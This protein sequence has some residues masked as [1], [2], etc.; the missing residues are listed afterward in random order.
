[1][2][3]AALETV[4]N[5]A[6]QA[7]LANEDV[8][9]LR[10]AVDTLALM[11]AAL[12]AKSASIARLRWLMF[13]ERTEKTSRLFPAKEAE[14]GDAPAGADAEQGAQAEPE[15]TAES[16][17]DQAKTKK[18][19]HGRNGAAA[20][21]GATKIPVP[22]ESLTKGQ[23]CPECQKGKLYPLRDP[24]TIIRIRG[25]APLDALLFLLECMRCNLCG[26]VFEAESPPE[27]GQ[28]K[29]D[30]S[31]A[32]MIGMVK[33]GAGLPF[34]RLEAL[35]KDLG[36]P[37]P[38]A[39]QWEVVASRAD[40]LIPAHQ[41][42]I[43]QAAQGEVLY[44]DD[45]TMKIL[46]L[47]G[48]HPRDKADPEAAPEA[49]EKRT[50]VFT[51]GIVSTNQGRRIALFFT[52]PKHAGENL[53][54][55]LALRA[56]DAG[57][58]IQMCDALSRN[59]PANFETLL[60]SCL[61]HGRRRFAE[62]AEF[63]PDQCRYVLE[64][65][66]DVYRNDELA[67]DRAMPPDERLAFHQTES[68]PL[69]E[70]LEKWLTEQIE[71]KKVE[72]NSGLGQAIKYMRKHWQKLTLFLRVPRAPLDSNIVERALK[73]AILNRKNAY[74]Y[75]TQN[76]ARVGD[77]YMTLIHTAE[78]AGV[79]AF[80]YLLALMRNAQ[81]VAENPADWMPWNYTERGGQAEATGPPA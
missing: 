4:L 49:D 74:F 80:H 44:N 66:R 65:L 67:R 73:K 17:T 23:C 70:A 48:S 54:A 22:H 46:A 61:T 35:Q 38:A 47:A 31:A 29:Y 69:M 71:E 21:T 18:P 60:G 41:E 78:M 34:T 11:T 33:Y 79:P 9:L 10:S 27:V 63:F 13:G 37:L 56:T 25:M 68:G 7:P 20:Y 57:P 45:T 72:P 43:R 26:E 42:L 15:A 28:E 64:T 76:G 16:A 62:V 75:K 50:G 77:I 24:K 40:A 53:A 30:D 81:A 12:E 19:G 2:D 1:V 52:G 14:G 58:P 36:I 55:V 3:I 32:A 5:R 39:T 6:Q 59:V 8:Q 51:S